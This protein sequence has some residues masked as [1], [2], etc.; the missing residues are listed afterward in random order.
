MV[1]GAQGPVVRVLGEDDADGAQ[2]VD[3][4]CRN[5]RSGHLGRTAVP[6]AGF[7]GR[8]GEQDADSGQVRKDLVLAQVGVPG[9]SWFWADGSGVAVAAPVGGLAV[10]PG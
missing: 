10:G 8:V 1:T 2:L 6:A 9:P 4:V 7:P 3:Q 5:R